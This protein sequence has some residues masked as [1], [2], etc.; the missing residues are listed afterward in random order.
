[1]DPIFAGLV[2]SLAFFLST[3]ALVALDRGQV[4]VV[5]RIVE[6]LGNLLGKSVSKSD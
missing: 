1:M 6:F 2:L 4:A 5:N 3:I